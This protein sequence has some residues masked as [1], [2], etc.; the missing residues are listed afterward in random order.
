VHRFFVSPESISGSH[1]CLEGG[2]ASQITRVLRGRPGEFV[3]V[4][5]GTG[6]EY[7]VVL[8]SVSIERVVGEVVD[9][10]MCEGEPGVHVTVS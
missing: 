6:M 3:I 10:G 7:R 1:V 8:R 9:S 2:V 4:L 5:G